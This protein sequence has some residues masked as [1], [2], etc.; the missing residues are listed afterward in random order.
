YEKKLSVIYNSIIIPDL[1]SE[2]VYR[3]NDKFNLVVAASYQ[4]LKNPIGLIKAISLMSDSEKN[5]LSINWYGRIEITKG[6]TR[7]YDEAMLLVKHLNLENVV[8]LNKEVKDIAE[9]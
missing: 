1:N 7:A 3:A 4:Y 9:K 5:S 6:D 2:Y 8:Y